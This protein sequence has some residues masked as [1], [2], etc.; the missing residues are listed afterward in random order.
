MA[1]M[2]DGGILLTRERTEVLGDKPA[3]LP[4]CTPQIP[5][6]SAWDRTRPSEVS[7]RQ[8]TV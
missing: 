7:G 8:L 6:G 5:H 1:L 3:P 2:V 4:L